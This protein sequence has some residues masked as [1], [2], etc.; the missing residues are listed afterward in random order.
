[1]GSA[2]IPEGFGDLLSEPL[3]VH[4]ATVRPDGQLQNNPMLF[5]W[6]GERFK[7]SLTKSRQKYRNLLADPRIAISVTD[8]ANPYRYLELRGTIDKIEDDANNDFLNSCAKRYMGLD[9]Y[10]YHPPGAERIIVS[11]VPQSTSHQG[12]PN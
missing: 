7:M 2:V 8:A 12:D 4:M 9:E 1:M 3:I 5:E 6:D 10:P 11:F